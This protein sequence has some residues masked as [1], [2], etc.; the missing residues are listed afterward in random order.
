M[1]SYARVAGE[2]RSTRVAARLFERLAPWHAWV[3][4]AGDTVNGSVA[5]YLGILA[6][7]LGCLDDADAFFAEAHAMHD[8]MKAPYCLAVTCLNWARMLLDR[9]RPGAASWPVRCT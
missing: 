8:R 1:T 3:D 7:T 4:V 5:L 9:D 6:A 2:L